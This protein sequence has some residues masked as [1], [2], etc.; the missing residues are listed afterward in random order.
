MDDTSPPRDPSPHRAAW[1]L[2]PW[3]VAGVAS[4]AE[5]AQVQ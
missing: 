5:R 2:I 1:D 4:A 3:V